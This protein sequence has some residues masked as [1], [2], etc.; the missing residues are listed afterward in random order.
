MNSSKDP[1]TDL[2][3]ERYGKWSTVA[4]ILMLAGCGGSAESREGAGMAL[5]SEVN[6]P[7]EVVTEAELPGTTTPPLPPAPAQS[8]G[9]TTPAR[10]APTTPAPAATP[11]PSPVPSRVVSVPTGTTIPAS[12]EIALS[13]RT[14][15]VGD[16][17]HA[18]VTEEILAADGMVLIPVGARLEGKVA[19]ARQSENANEEALL[20]L[21]FEH[22]LIRGERFPIN[23]AVAEVLVE[24]SAD[25][26]GAR[27]AATV[28]TGAAAGAVVGRI[29]GGDTRS[30][31]AGAVVGAAAGTG[32][33][34]TTREGHASIGEGTRVVV[35]LNAPTILSGS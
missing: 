32:V 35:R 23:A 13:T 29:L 3:Y 8:A 7:V 2:Q 5:E 4:L 33:A 26:S 11:A 24:S 1:R 27:T 34:L 9:A 22:L 15:K 10:P 12:M 16:V 19:E 18:R 25:A 14:H 6:E 20:L 21:T 17:F 28:A 31:V 30:T